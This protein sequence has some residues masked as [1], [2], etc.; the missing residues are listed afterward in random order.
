[1]LGT[2]VEC[3]VAKKIYYQNQAADVLITNEMVR[4]GSDAKV[5]W[6]KDLNKAALKTLRRF[7]WDVV[8]IA[9]GG[10]LLCA[11]CLV[12]SEGSKVGVLLVFVT[13]IICGL[14]VASVSAKRYVLRVRTKRLKTYQALESAN[15][16][17]VKVVVDAV[18]KAIQ[19]Y[20]RLYRIP[21]PQDDEP[22]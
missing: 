10:G 5:W 21:P 3:A 2:Q 20:R 7:R 4:L 16:A 12:A 9:V 19:D 11:T 22:L 1:M 8:A 6:I 13:A 15:K 14:A 18:N 17:D